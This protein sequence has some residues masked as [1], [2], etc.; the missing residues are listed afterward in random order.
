MKESICAQHS[1]IKIPIAYCE[2]FIHLF[3]LHL[4]RLHLF[5]LHVLLVVATG[6]P[7]QRE[8]LF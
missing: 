6:H 5:Q 2:P 4:F 3:R 7:K 8:K 1:N